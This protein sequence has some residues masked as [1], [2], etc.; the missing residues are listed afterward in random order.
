MNYE[1]WIWTELLAFDN[2]QPDQGVREFLDKTG[3]IP[4]VICLMSSTPDIVLQYQPLDEERVLPPTVCSRDGHGG[5]EERRRQDWTNFQLKSLVD[6]LHRAGVEAYISLFPIFYKNKYYHEWI[7]DHQEVLQEWDFQ[8]RGLEMNV[9][10]RLKDG[11]YVEDFFIAK[12]VETV[13]GYGF[14]GWHGP[15]G[16]GPLGSGGLGCTDCGDDLMGQFAQTL[17]R[18]LPDC[19]TCVSNQNTDILKERMKWIWGNLRKEW[20]EFNAARWETFWRKMTDAMHRVSR[21]TA[22]NSAWTKAP[23]EALYRFGIDYKRIAGTGV[24]AMVVEAVAANYYLS[25]NARDLHFNF[26]AM[27]MQIKAYAPEMKLIFLHGV[28]DI[29]E[30][31][32]LIHHCPTNLERE[33]YS[34]S[35]TFLQDAGGGL[36]RCADGFLVCLGDGIK[37]EEWRWLKEHWDLGFGPVPKRILGATAVWSDYAFR[38][39]LDSY[40]TTG[41][42]QDH[43]LLYPLMEDGVQIQGYVRAEDIKGASGPL[44]VFNQQL[45][46]EKELSE[47]L[48]YKNGPVIM[49]GGRRAGLPEPDIFIEDTPASDSLVC[50]IYFAGH[51][52]ESV[53]LNP[54]RKNPAPYRET[55]APLSFWEGEHCREFS[56]QFMACC[57]EK[58]AK[59]VN[60]VTVTDNRRNG[61]TAGKAPGQATEIEIAPGVSRVAVSNSAYV[62]AVTK[63]DL[64]REIKSVKVLS[65]FP[66]A[67]IVPEGSTFKIKVPGK[68]IVVLEVTYA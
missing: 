17:E 7:S 65:G 40:I 61:A 25:E 6:N 36:K 35:N 23:F 18:E 33:N 4:K 10:R 29:V 67:D 27:L 5:N 30:Q 51:K 60:S 14:D 26:L 68:G 20:I 8:G 56:G 44:L 9:T 54:E 16:W 11:T 59:I 52:K 58:I 28:K 3:F 55:G 62:Y 21:K 53:T 31:Y 39:S 15:D 47:L 38:G 1:A 43:R 41:A 22:I 48:G 49:L 32:D 57:S 13:L 24:D 64:K 19:V 42:P 34:L 63:I 46:P 37:K 12:T 2:A 66:I 45:L 50:L